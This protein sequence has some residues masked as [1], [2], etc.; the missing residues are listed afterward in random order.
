MTR[1][2]REVL[3][4]PKALEG[5]EAAN[6]TDAERDAIR[7]VLAELSTDISRGYRIAF[8]NPST[9]RIDVGRFRIHFRFNDRKLEVGFIGVY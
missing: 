4:A 8:V 7:T 9:Y 3:I 6:P 5:M 1:A 2:R